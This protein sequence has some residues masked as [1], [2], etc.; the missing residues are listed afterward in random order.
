MRFF[1]VFLC[2]VVSHLAGSAPHPLVPRTASQ[3]FI[4]SG[5]FEGG[6]LDL[7]NLERIRFWKDPKTGIERWVIDFSSLAERK[8]QEQAPYFKISVIPPNKLFLPHQKEEE[9]SPA[10][11]VVQLSGVKNNFI[12][13]KRIKQFLRKS[14]L[15]RSLRI[16]PPLDNGHRLI[17]WVLSDSVVVEPHQPISKEG[18]IVLDLKPQ[19]K[20]DEK[21]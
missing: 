6:G 7:V 4:N 15:V 20:L 21:K 16:Y 2:S 14:D 18:R 5:V 13:S 9:L 10:R 19:R 11:I 1:L 12:R 8:L 3:I 17:E